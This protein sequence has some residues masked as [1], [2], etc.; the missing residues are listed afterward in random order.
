VV[1]LLCNFAAVAAASSVALTLM[2]T[3]AYAEK[4]VALVVDLLPTQC[5]GLLPA[6]PP[7]AAVRVTK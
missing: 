2:T 3:P 6:C 7:A 4:H 5:A 1:R